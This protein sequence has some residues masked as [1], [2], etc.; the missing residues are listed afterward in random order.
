MKFYALAIPFPHIHGAFRE[1]L[2]ARSSQCVLANGLS[3]S[4]A[5]MVEPLAVFLHVLKQSGPVYGKN[6]LVTCAG[7]IGLITILVVTSAGASNIVVTDI[8][9]KGLKV[10]H[11]LGASETI[12]VLKDESG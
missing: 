11:N 6:V 7:P 5:A 9:D 4:Q 12:S 3:P 2:V 8:L 10:T 1:E